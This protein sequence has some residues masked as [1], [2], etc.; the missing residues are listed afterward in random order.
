MKTTV[1]YIIVANG[2]PYASVVS[3]SAIKALVADVRAR[4]WNGQPCDIKVYKQTT[5]PYELGEDNDK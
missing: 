5:E 3:E 4:D 1:E 2:R